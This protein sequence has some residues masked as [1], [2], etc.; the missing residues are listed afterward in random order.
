[1]SQP[2]IIYDD[3]EMDNQPTNNINAWIGRLKPGFEPPPAAQ[4]VERSL[5]TIPPAV[6]KQLPPQS[7]PI[8]ELLRYTL[9]PPQFT[10]SIRNDEREAIVKAAAAL[11][12]VKRKGGK[13]VGN[14]LDVDEDDGSLSL[15]LD[16][17][18][19]EACARTFKTVKLIRKSQ[20]R[21]RLA[22]TQVFSF[23]L[24]GVWPACSLPSHLPHLHCR[25]CPPCRSSACLH[26]PA[27]CLPSLDKSAK[28]LHKALVQPQR[29]PAAVQCPST[30]TACLPATPC[31]PPASMPASPRE[32]TVAILA[33][34]CSQIRRLLSAA[35]KSTCRH[36]RNARRSLPAARKSV[37]IQP[38]RLPL[39][40]S[41]K[42]VKIQPQ[43]PPPTAHKSAAPCLLHASPPASPRRYGRNACRP[44]LAAHYLPPATLP[45]S[46]R[47]YSRNVRPR[48]LPAA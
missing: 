44:P 35:R 9:L 17:P 1:M 11:S 25:T 37:K 16:L 45:A 34:R 47:R 14:V 46:P 22:A 12:T 20:A 40:A 30:A 29:P 19:L 31:P 26:L 42:S 5:L 24:P 43:R 33:A 28:T 27:T 15:S 23:C 7:L 39:R 36:S 13:G 4:A 41:R 3:E 18:S 32:D 38:Q 21:P 10:D 48:P 6:L 2:E 8:A